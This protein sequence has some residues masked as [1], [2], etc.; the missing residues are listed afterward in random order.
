[1]SSAPTGFLPHLDSPGSGGPPT[2]RLIV[3]AALVTVI[4]VGMQI[5]FPPKKDEPIAAPAP[6]L[7]E[8]AAVG[9]APIAVV[10]GVNATERLPE[11]EVIVA[12]TVSS[13]TDAVRGGYKTTLTSH[14]AQMKAVQ[15]DGYS[16][17]SW[18]RTDGSAALVDLAYATQAGRHMMALV[19]R[20]GDVN[21]A[22]DASFV[23]TEETPLSVTF[24]R[25]TETGVRVSRRYEFDDKKFSL[26]HTLTLKNESAVPHVAELDWVLP[27]FEHGGEAS[28]SMLSR[29]S[30]KHGAGACTIDSKRKLFQ[31][32]EIHDDADD[33]KRTG[34]VS[35]AY[36]DQFYFVGAVAFDGLPTTGCEAKPFKV[37]DG[38]GAEVKGFEMLVH[39]APTSLA[40]GET[41][42]FASDAYFGPKQGDM[43]KAFGH[44]LDESLDYGMLSLLCKPM[45]YGL[46]YLRGVL[47]NYGWAIIALTLIIFAL[48]F[49]LTHKPQI[50]MRKMGKVMKDLK[51][52]IDLLKEK[53]GHDQRLMAEKQQQ[54]FASKGIDPFAQMKGCLPMF[55][56]MPIWFALYR[57]LSQ[58]VE[59]YQQ[60]FPPLG[61]LDL[62]L[63]DTIIF[64]F[65]LL[66]FIVCGLMLL[67][68]WMQPPPADQPQMKYMMWGMPIFFLFI[69][70]NTAA[71][72]SMYMIT[73]SIL[74]MA[75]SSYI[76]KKHPQE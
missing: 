55:I 41:K 36:V 42:S 29:S 44:D 47:G 65:P 50:E 17:P 51:P 40:A 68:T 32:E 53:Y 18:T 52:E 39:Q 67:Q 62:T 75:Q 71:G 20:G 31:T 76:K 66:P 49:P 30:V 54:L 2:G 28:A 59:L 34:S 14:G 37:K 61:V 5:A 16:D 35:T 15:L 58:S 69:M 8:P 48:Q 11:R 19:S 64:G 45:L 22:P 25:V 7:S 27:G 13:T 1:M 60:P 63:P 3:T 23:I 38:K 46:V 33:T 9:D 73:N 26:K 24:E 21:L 12:H 74:R 72:L 10:A 70:F 43:L 4:F 57:T 6:T 56:S